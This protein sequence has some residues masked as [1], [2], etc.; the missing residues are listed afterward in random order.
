MTGYYIDMIENDLLLS[1]SY[2]NDDYSIVFQV[3]DF[4]DYYE[5]ITE[6]RSH[7]FE[8]SFLLKIQLD[9]LQVLKFTYL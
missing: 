5:I 3:D 4:G 1:E 9:N 2:E 8:Y 6:I 7:Q